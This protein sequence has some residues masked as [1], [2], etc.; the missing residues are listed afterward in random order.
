M[1]LVLEMILVGQQQSVANGAIRGA[2]VGGIIGGAIG[3]LMWF[4]RRPSDKK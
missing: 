1:N 4:F 2:V 3:F